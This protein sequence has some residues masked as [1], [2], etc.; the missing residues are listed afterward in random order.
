MKPKSVKKSLFTLDRWSGIFTA[1]LLLAIT[2]I[3]LL[4]VVLSLPVANSVQPTAVLAPTLM[5]VDSAGQ[6]LVQTV[7]PPPMV[8]TT[9]VVVMGGLL[10]L[11]VLSVVLRE[12]NWFRR[13]P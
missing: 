10:V 6:P 2:V 12:L 5:P 3:V 13:Q 4:V 8:D 11:F 1:L 7:T 9:G